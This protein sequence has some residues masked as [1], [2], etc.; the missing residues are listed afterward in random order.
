MLKVSAGHSQSEEQLSLAI[1]EDIQLLAKIR[2]RQ[3]INKLLLPLIENE[4]TVPV[5]FL[6]CENSFVDH[7]VQGADEEWCPDFNALS[8]GNEQKEKKEVID[9]SKNFLPSSLLE[10]D[11]KA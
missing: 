2:D 6:E 3:F 11:I 7:P 4:V 1:I 5:S 10:P 9:N 8:C